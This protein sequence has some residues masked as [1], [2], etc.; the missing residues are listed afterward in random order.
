M[1]EFEWSSPDSLQQLC[2]I[3]KVVDVID[4]IDDRLSQ[5]IQSFAVSGSELATLSARLPDAPVS[6]VHSMR[7]G[8]SASR[9]SLDQIKTVF[10]A[11]AP[12][13]R[14]ALFS[15]TRSALV[16]A[17]RVIFVLGSDDTEHQLQ[18]ARTVLQQEAASFLRGV[19]A[20]DTFKHLR[21]FRPPE[22]LTARMHD[23]IRELGGERP[24]GDGKTIGQMAL[25][26]GEL[27][28]RSGLAD[29]TTGDALAEHVAYIWNAYSGEAHAFGWPRLIP[30]DFVADFGLVASV[31][32]LAFDLALRK[33]GSQTT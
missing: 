13:R 15:M 28:E 26:V 3:L 32:H 14:T 11:K 33:A 25:A 21:A 9:G 23:Q 5:E 4:S 29:A 10:E 24:P 2:Q 6:L 31:S 22:G 19:E 1:I 16:G 20:M 8:L 7:A 27:L 18:N 17:A 12:M 30:G